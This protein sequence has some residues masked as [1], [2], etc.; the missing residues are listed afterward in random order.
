MFTADEFADGA[1][2]ILSTLSRHQIQGSFFFTGRFLRN[3]R[4]TSIVKRIQRQ[5][6]C[7]G[8]H[9]NNHLL[10]CDWNN[11]DS[12]L[13]SKAEFKKDLQANLDAIKKF[14]RSKVGIRYFIPPYEWYNDSIAAWTKEMGL[15]LINF[16]PGTLVTA[17]YT[18]PEL[19]NY[20][21]S[22]VIYNSIIEKEKT[23]KNGLNG[24][25]LLV[26]FGVDARRT[27]K[28]YNRL[29]QLV[30]EL[31]RKDYKFVPLAELLE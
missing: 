28:F 6:H 26:H 18:W 8:P 24:F 30:S 15:Q 23:D 1:D 19:P 10:Y 11:R 13:V 16:S 31:T 22:E 7:I 14:G 27:D 12:L 9:S 5:G 3:K 4:Y 20:R 2:T 21:S 25:I 17:D 29:G